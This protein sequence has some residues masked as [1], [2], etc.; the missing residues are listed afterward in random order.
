MGLYVYELS[1]LLL[2]RNM[3]VDTQP[4]DLIIDSKNQQHDSKLLFCL[5]LKVC[6][7]NNIQTSYI[8]R[9]LLCI[10]SK[11]IAHIGRRQRRHCFINKTTV[12]TDLRTVHKV[13][14]QC[15]NLSRCVREFFACRWRD[16][17]H[18]RYE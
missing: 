10:V 5:Q 16:N 7:I 9:R 3:Q 1:S 18:G 15:Y 6:F 4:Y 17:A 8:D 12:E 11:E 2:A 14:Q 13:Y